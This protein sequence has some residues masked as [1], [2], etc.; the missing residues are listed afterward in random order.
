MTKKLLRIASVNVNGV[1]AAFRKGMGEWLAARDVDILAL[2]EVRASTDDLTGLLGDEWDVLHD[3]A[4]AKGRAGVALASRNRAT[5]HRVAL[6]ADD[7]DSAGRWLEADY[8]VGDRTITVVSTYVHSGGVGTP[9]QDE[10]VK[11]LDAMTE[12]L[13]QL[14]AHSPLAVVMGDLNVG[15]RTLDIKNWKGN[16]KK[17]GFLPE[18]R[19]YFDRFLGA[20]GEDGYNAGAGL[21]WIDL[22][23]R[24]AGEV[25]GPYTWWSQR[26]QAFDTDTGWRIDYQLATPELAALARSYEID[27][28]DS[29]DTRW[30]DHAPVVVDYEL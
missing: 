10:K 12:R 4:T 19:A 27:R 8:E 6:G 20:E 25:P 2:Q 29:W 3:E 11:F 23:R 5:I 24:F 9:K 26:G 21:G 1:R 13:P 15:H 22:G 14:Q 28:A 18:E 16:V 30:S 17:A 7:F